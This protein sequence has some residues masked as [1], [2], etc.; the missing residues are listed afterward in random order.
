[1]VY[2]DSRRQN[3][4]VARMQ[5]K[6]ARDEQMELIRLRERILGKMAAGV[7]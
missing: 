2:I 1:M 6:Q 7:S 5:L 4:D 3:L